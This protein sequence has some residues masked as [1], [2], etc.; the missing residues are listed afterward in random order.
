MNLTERDNTVEELLDTPLANMRLA[1]QSFHNLSQMSAMLGWTRLAVKEVA[2][3]VANY[4][5]RE[6]SVLD[7]ATGAAHIPAAIARWARE[8]KLHAQITASDLSEYA[9]E[10][11][12][13]TC[14]DLPEV[15]LEQQN[16]LALT[17][18]D[19]AFDLVLCQGA[20]HHFAPDQAVPLL[21]ELARVARRAV[22]VTD[23]QRSFPLYLGA[24]LFLHITACNPVTRHD[25]LA[26]IRRAYR[27]REV[28]ALAEQAGLHPVTIQS[29]WHFR[30][31]LTWQR[32]NGSSRA[33]TEQPIGYPDALTSRRSAAR[34]RSP[35]PP[36]QPRTTRCG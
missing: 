28:Q 11:A 15:R 31:T 35:S 29:R 2:Q 18:P 4:R 30:Q 5:L 14:A 25:G 21:K 1:E 12:R 27:P 36:S 8:Q 10:A 3:L 13:C 23:L 24:W 6:F 34:T 32:C 16:A 19:Q 17:Y 26:S 9:L 33:G 7:V 20:L 22:I